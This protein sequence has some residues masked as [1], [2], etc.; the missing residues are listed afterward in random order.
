LLGVPKRTEAA[1]NMLD[2]QIAFALAPPVFDP[3]KQIVTGHGWMVDSHT[4]G[5]LTVNIGLE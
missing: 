2:R 5:M 3:M 4:S 1:L